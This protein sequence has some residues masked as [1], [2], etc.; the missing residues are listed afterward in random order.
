MMFLFRI[1]KMRIIDNRTSTFL[2][3]REDLAD[4]FVTTGN[5]DLQASNPWMRE[6]HL[7]KKRT[8]LAA[9]VSNARASRI[10]TE[11]ENVE[12]NQGAFLGDMGY[13]LFSPR[14]FQMTSTGLRRGQKQP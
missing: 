3:F 14:R 2:F 1:N 8:F 10:L 4:V 9:T 7:D 6:K 13:V 11:V 5:D 12:D